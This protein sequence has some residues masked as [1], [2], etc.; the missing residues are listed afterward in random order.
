MKKN[1]FVSFRFSD[2]AK[3]KDKIVAL[4]KRDNRFVDFSEDQ[5][6]SMMSKETIKKYLYS[7]IRKTSVTI[8]LV[9]PKALNHQKNYLG[10]YDDWMYDEIRYSLEDR[11]LNR[12]SGLVA[13]YTPEVKDML[14]EGSTYKSA[15]TGKIENSTRIK[16]VNNLFRKN[17]M[18][19][20][21]KYKK[22]KT[23]GIFDSEYDSYCQLVSY[24][25]FI[26]DMDKYIDIAY[27]KK[28]ICDHYD[29]KIDLNKINN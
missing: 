9:T 18:N 29:L 14:I 8:I 27:E 26:D 2:G 24:E 4:L 5:D 11:E 20:Y 6:R 19:V 10:Q 13:V 25:K 21:P 22:C 16:N 3:Y 1:V 17:M 7:K 23:E 28:Q 12:T 15:E